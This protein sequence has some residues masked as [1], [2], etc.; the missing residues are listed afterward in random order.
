M[1]KQ[2]YLTIKKIFDENKGYAWTKEIIDKG[3][4]TSYLYKLVENGVI[5]RIKRGLYHWDDYEIDNN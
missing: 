4:H 3:I 1:N 5:S 2:K